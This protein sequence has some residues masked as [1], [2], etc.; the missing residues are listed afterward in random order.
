MGSEPAAQPIS[1]LHN[2]LLLKLCIACRDTI[3]GRL[4]KVSFAAPEVLSWP[5]Q[6]QLGAGQ[7]VA[8][9]MIMSRPSSDQPAAFACMG[10]IPLTDY[11]C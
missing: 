7:A 11:S 10:A 9:Y 6:L 3:Y 2:M 5:C 4:A 1:L 8:C